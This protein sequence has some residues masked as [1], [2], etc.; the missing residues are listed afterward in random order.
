MLPHLELVT[1][2][3]GI[4]VDGKWRPGIG[5]PSVFG[6]I[7]VA[8][9]LI[10]ALLCYRAA[11]ADRKL[12]KAGRKDSTPL[13]W[14][15]MAAVLLLLGINKQLDLQ[16]LLTEQM[17]EIAR[18]RDWLAYRDQLK[19][20]FI[21]TLTLVGITVLTSMVWVTRRAVKRTWLAIAGATFLVVFILVR[22]SSF[23]HVDRW[24]GLPVGAANLNVVLELGGICSIAIAASMCKPATPGHPRRQ[25]PAE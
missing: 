4:M 23:H 3:L 8:G 16:T 21:L 17:R 9:Y 25:E 10:A 15:A 11:L 12:L 14:F 22:A 18:R 20:W 2:A 24:L 5:D 1:D 19:Q 7:T 13:F 6:W